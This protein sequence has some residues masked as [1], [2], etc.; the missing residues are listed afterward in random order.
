MLGPAVLL[1]E[2][3]LC[4]VCDLCAL[5]ALYAPKVVIFDSAYLHRY[6]GTKGDENVKRE[7][8]DKEVLK[9]KGGEKL[10]G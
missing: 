8:E 5:Y 2:I 9:E 1:R 3:G 4:V 7:A 10:H 6:K